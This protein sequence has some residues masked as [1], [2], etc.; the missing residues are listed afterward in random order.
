MDTLLLANNLTKSLVKNG[1]FAEAQQFALQ[2][3]EVARRSLGETH[4]ES[5]VAVTR[6]ADALYLNPNASRADVIQAKALVVNQREIRHRVFGSGSAHPCIDN[7]TSQLKTIEKLLASK[8][9]RT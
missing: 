7:I 9:L 2:Q 6:L 5:M 8:N 4:I 1:L 3:L